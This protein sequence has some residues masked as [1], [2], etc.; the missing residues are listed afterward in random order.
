MQRVIELHLEAREE[1][2][3]CS[4]RLAGIERLYKRHGRPGVLGGAMYSRNKV[5]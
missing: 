1:C 3:G 4:M 2:K 5:F